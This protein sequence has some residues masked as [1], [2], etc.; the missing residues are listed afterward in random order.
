MKIKQNC[1]KILIEE[2]HFIHG[3]TARMFLLVS[4]GDVELNGKKKPTTVTVIDAAHY[5]SHTDDHCPQLFSVIIDK[6]TINEPLFRPNHI[7]TLFFTQTMGT[8]LWFLMCDYTQF[9]HDVCIKSVHAQFQYTM[10][11]GKRRSSCMRWKRRKDMSTNDEVPL[12]ILVP[13]L[14]WY[15]GKGE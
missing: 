3:E 12:S 9:T 4:S 2:E 5:W 8:F 1:V 15:E 10:L 13:K 14:C 7:L 6:S 11:M